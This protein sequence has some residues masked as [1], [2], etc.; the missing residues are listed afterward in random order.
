LLTTAQLQTLGAATTP[1]PTKSPWGEAACEWN[2]NDVAIHLSPDTTTGKGIAQVYST[3]TKFDSF[4]QTTIAGYPAVQVDKQEI[5]CG[6]FVGVSD[7]QVLQLTVFVDGQSNPDYHNPCAFAP[8]VASA[9]LG[10]LP[11]GQ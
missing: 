2:T 4:Q 1:S 9:V 8:K 7:T 3:K 11:A 5:S 10:N 6:L